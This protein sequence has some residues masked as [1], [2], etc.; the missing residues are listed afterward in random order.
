M[1]LIL[2]SKEKS[3][4]AGVNEGLSFPGQS[5]SSSSGVAGHHSS[6]GSKKGGI[7]KEKDKDKDKMT[8]KPPKKKQH[9]REP[10]PVVG[11]EVEVVGEAEDILSFCLLRVLL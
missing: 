10:L 7:K 9:S 2:S 3:E 11:K 6:S 4:V 8:S 5:S 1:K